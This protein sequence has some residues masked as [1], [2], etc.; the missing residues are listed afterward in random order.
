MAHSVE[1]RLPFVDYRVVELG[2]ALPASAKLRRGHGKAIVRDV[3]RGRVPDVIRL[4][5]YKRGFDVEQAR[6]IA[7]GL[8]A[9]MRAALHDDWPRL[10]EFVAPGV[11]IDDAFS[12]RELGMSKTAFVD[13]TTLLWLAARK[14]SETRASVEIPTAV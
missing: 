13:A 11:T 12:D 8:G 1:S 5:R 6:W 3:V 4:S 7:G 2:L 10:R 9:S 14:P